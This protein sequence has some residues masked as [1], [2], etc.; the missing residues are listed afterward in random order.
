MMSL[1]R[2]SSIAILVLSL[3]VASIDTTAAFGVVVPSSST[4]PAPSATRLNFFKGLGDA[5]KS[6]DSLG[7]APDAGLKGGPKFNENVTVNGK[8]VPGAVAGQK[9]T[10]VA[11]KVRVKIPVNCQA[12]DCGTCMVKLNGRKVKA[13]QVGLPAGKAN[14]ETLQ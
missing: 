14:I 9:L 7:K 5:F 4:R 12:G 11:N 3:L 10:A 6:D 1:S 2:T 8:S 13:C